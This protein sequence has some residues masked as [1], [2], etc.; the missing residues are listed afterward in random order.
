MS[1]FMKEFIELCETDPDRVYGYMLFE[2]AAKAT[3]RELVY[4]V[5]ELVYA[6]CDHHEYRSQADMLSRA[7]GNVAADYY[8]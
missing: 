8:E 2:G 7:A 5:R 1:E 3:Q 4:I 6:M